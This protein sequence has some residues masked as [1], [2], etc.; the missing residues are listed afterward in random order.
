MCV[1]TIVDSNISKDCKV[2]DDLFILEIFSLLE[3]RIFV[4][5]LNINKLL[6]L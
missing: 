6:C 4:L 5:S 2:F 1:D 3:L